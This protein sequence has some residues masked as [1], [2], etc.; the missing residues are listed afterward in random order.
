MR[1]DDPNSEPGTPPSARDVP[2]FVV[3]FDDED[4]GLG[5]GGLRLLDAEHGEVKRMYVDPSARGT[6]VARAILEALDTEAQA[7]G[8]RR[9]VLETG[10]LQ[11]DAIRFYEREGF[12][13]IPNFGAYVDSPISLCFE[14]AID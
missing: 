3:A 11:P 9:L 7:R 2:F 8:W 14:R 5:C 10:Y 4:H 12:T 6:G 13:R 1:Y